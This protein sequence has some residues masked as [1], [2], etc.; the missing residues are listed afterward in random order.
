M[1]RATPAFRAAA[2]KHGKQTKSRSGSPTYPR[3]D[4]SPP[5]HVISSLASWG[6]VILAFDKRNS[7][8]NEEDREAV[9]RAVRQLTE[10]DLELLRLIAQVTAPASLVR[11]LVEQIGTIAGAAY[12]IGAHGAMTETARVFFEQSRAQQMRLQRAT[13][14]KEQC[15][16]EA[17]E[18]E[19]KAIGGTVPSPRP[20]KYAESIRE[21][22]NKRLTPRVVS[23]HAIARRLRARP[24][25]S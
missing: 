20:W 14:A 18:A 3:L 23:V 9:E 7:E 25:E 4:L 22:V 1:T 16:R 10:G 17:I 5:E 13:N 21:Q 8:L 12:L 24:G 11:R 6:E 19:M 2:R 15:L